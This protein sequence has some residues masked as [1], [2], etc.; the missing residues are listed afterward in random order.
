MKKNYPNSK[1]SLSRRDFISNCGKL[2]TGC[3]IATNSIPMV[4]GEKASGSK[5]ALLV[6]GGCCHDYDRQ[7]DILSEGISQRVKTQWDILFEMDEKKSKAWLSKPGWADKYDFIVYNHCF[8]HEKDAAFVQSITDIHK[9]GKPAIALHCAMHSY[10]WNIPAKEGEKKAWNDMLGVSSKGHGPK[11][12][13]TISKVKGHDH[14]VMKDMPDGWRT[15]EGELY[16]VQEV[17]EDTTVLAYGDN[18]KNKAPKKPQACIWVNTHGKG[19]IFATTI[20]HHN[21]TMSTKEY[22]D[23]LGNAVRW[24]TEK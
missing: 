14:P 18:G 3:A 17:Y 12:P 1:S 9:A 10:H 16:N 8:A 5:R 23:M 13:I 22:L 2:A 11:A 19:R 21:S 7:K 15:P 20:G 6:T 24:I 4:H